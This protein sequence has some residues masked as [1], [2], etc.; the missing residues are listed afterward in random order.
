MRTLHIGLIGKVPLYLVKFPI[1]LPE[2]W[3]TDGDDFMVW[4]EKRKSL[5]DVVHLQKVFD[6]FLTPDESASEMVELENTLEAAVAMGLPSGVAFERI[7]DYAVETDQEVWSQEN[8]LHLFDGTSHLV[9]PGAMTHAEFANRLADA[10]EK[11]HPLGLV[12]GEDERHVIH[13]YLRES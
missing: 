6:H 11:Q 7:T 12:L 4:G 13:E 10:L 8:R 9:V 3:M 1:A 5:S 2:G